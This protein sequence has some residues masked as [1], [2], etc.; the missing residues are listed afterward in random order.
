[1][2]TVEE[3][4]NMTN[5]IT[6]K[7][8]IEKFKEIADSGNTID[9]KYIGTGNQSKHM[10]CELLY[11]NKYVKVEAKQFNDTRNASQKFLVIFGGILKGRSLPIVSQDLED[12]PE[13]Y[14][15]MIESK[16]LER[17]REYIEEI[18]E[19]DWSEFGRIFEVE[20]FFVV[21][22]DQEKIEVRDWETQTIIEEVT[23]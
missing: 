19:K 17:I 15:V 16:Y 10:D 6:E 21:D 5:E 7:E 2:E 13:V 11:K 22:V 23:R 9:V 3:V 4:I 20:Y 18:D 12:F 14:G 8:L 1:M